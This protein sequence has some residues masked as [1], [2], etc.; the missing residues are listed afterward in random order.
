LLKWVGRTLGILAAL[1]LVTF[2]AFRLSPWPAARI[3]R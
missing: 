2:A 3:I 1:V